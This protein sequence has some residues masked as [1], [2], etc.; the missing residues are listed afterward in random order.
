MHKVQEF[1]EFN[2]AL[3]AIAD[4]ENVSQNIAV[5]LRIAFEGGNPTLRAW[6]ANY[7]IKMFNVEIGGVEDEATAKASRL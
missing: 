2:N 4:G 1:N 5:I 7:M 6:A 3:K